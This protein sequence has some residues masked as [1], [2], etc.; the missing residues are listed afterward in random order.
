ML[1]WRFPAGVSLVEVFDAEQPKSLECARTGFRDRDA[2]LLFRGVRL[3]GSEGADEAEGSVALKLIGRCSSCGWKQLVHHGGQLQAASQSF[4]SGESLSKAMM[5]D[6]SERRNCAASAPGHEETWRMD[7]TSELV[8]AAQ[9]G[10][11]TW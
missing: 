2:Q 11:W 10:H 7:M 5:A 3:A 8:V 4:V 1:R 6:W 9:D